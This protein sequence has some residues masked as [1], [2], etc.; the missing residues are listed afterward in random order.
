MDLLT[1]LGGGCISTVVWYP[2]VL[3]R[4]RYQVPVPYWYGTGTR[5]SSWK[6][7]SELFTTGEQ[8]NDQTLKTVQLYCL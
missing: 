8:I 3:V 4:T 5:Y 1:L 7:E 2:L 6:W